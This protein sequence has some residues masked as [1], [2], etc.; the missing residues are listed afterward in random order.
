MSDE[1]GC[2]PYRI[3]DV[4]AIWKRIART[5]EV[6]HGVGALAITL[7]QL[8]LEVGR[9]AEQHNGAVD[10]PELTRVLRVLAAPDRMSPSDWLRMKVVDQ[11]GRHGKPGHPL[12]LRGLRCR[13]LIASFESSGDVLVTVENLRGGIASVKSCNFGNALEGAIRMAGARSEDL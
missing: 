13:K 12:D 6:L 7:A 5:A 11:S 3:D 10:H 2:G 8:R 9:L 1:V 4:L